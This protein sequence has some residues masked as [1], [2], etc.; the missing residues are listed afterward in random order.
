MMETLK[1]VH[2]SCVAVSGAGFVVRGALML[3]GSPLPGARLVR[4][5]PHVVDSVLL[6]SGIAMAALA[7]LS[8][9]AHP[10]LATKLALLV[11]YIALGS[12]A[13]NYGRTR[14]VRIACLAGAL[15][16]FGFMVSVALYRDP[17]GLLRPVSG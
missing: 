2:V 15:A 7:R 10:W 6:A 14:S 1:V 4:V 16:C 5:A 13:L 11:V 9:L 8:P 12:L 3:A 17:L